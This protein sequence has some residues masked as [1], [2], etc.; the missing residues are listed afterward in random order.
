MNWKND[1][2]I[3]LA[4]AR[5][6]APYARAEA[7]A[8]GCK[9]TES[10]DDSVTL[11]GSMLDALRLNLHLRTAHRVLVPV[12][13]FQAKN[14]EHLYRHASTIPWEEIIPADGYFTTHGT[15]HNDTIRDCRVAAMRLKD[16]IV[17]RIRSARGRR[18]DSGKEDS[19][20]SV[21]LYWHE[22]DLR[23]FIDT[24][25]V[26]LSRRGYR[27]IPGKAPMQEALAAA[28]VMATGW[29]PSTPFISPMCGSGTPAIEAAMIAKRRAP[30]LTRDRFAFMSLVGYGDGGD[31]SPEAFWK[32]ERDKAIA[33]ER[34]SL[35]M[36]PIVATDISHEAIR[37]SR[38][39]AKAAQMERYITFGVCDFTMT[40]LPPPPGAIFMNPEY[41][42][43]MGAAE[44][45]EPLYARIGT[46]YADNPGYLRSIFTSSPRLAK[47][48]KLP[49]SSLKPFFNGALACRL[50]SF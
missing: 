41:G 43:R 3:V 40:R 21:F 19:G 39:N 10:D 15:I 27:L 45:L 4:C 38:A 11:R 48:T 29:D 6:L 28:V 46:W 31:D 18:P 2:E 22:R 9:V 1:S 25:G 8:L 37:I 5:H 14:L 50:V 42:E 24:S 36:P 16:A 13:R 49:F 7:E 33:A 34:P 47:A 32:A 35:E 26:A 17:D 20:A 30:G 23:I 44:D 12:G